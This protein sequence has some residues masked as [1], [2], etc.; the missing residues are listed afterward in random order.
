[1]SVLF[2]NPEDRFKVTVKYRAEEGIVKILDDDDKAKDG[3]E[4]I[5]ITCRKPNFESSQ[6]ILHASTIFT[7]NG[8]PVVD[9]LRVRKALI[10]HLTVAWD[11]TDDN[12]KPI[13]LGPEK[14]SAMH[15]SIAAALCGKI[16]VEMGD[17]V[18]LFL[19]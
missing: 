13:P 15:P 17:P 9:M 5:T 16:E 1:M 3:D 7:E 2:I 6:L 11:A 8:Q 18:G 12:G 14:I 10:Y 4:S 19:G